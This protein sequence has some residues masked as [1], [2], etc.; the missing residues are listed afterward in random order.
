M[1]DTR[2]SRQPWIRRWRGDACALA[3]LLALIAVTMWARLWREPGLGDWDVSTQYLPWYAFLG[4]H[5]RHLDVPGWNPRIF[6]GSPSAA[7]PQS[8]WMYLPTMALFAVFSPVTAFRLL[9]ASLLA[10][11]GTATYLFARLLGIGVV[12]GLAAGVVFAFGPNLGASTCCSIHLQLSTWLPVAFI[13]IELASRAGSWSHRCLAWTLSAVAVSQMLAAWVGQGAYY[14]LLAIGSFL[15]YRCL[16]TAPIRLSAMR[17]RIGHFAAGSLVTFGVALGLAAAGLLPRLDFAPRTYVGSPAYQGADFAADRGQDWWTVIG[18]LVSYR[19]GWRPYVIGFAVLLCAALA[20]L[21]PRRRPHTW[22]FVV[23]SLVV[24]MLPLRPTPIHSLFYLLPRFR[25]LHLHDPGRVLAILP[26][27]IAMLVATGIDALPDLLR[28]RWA[29]AIP[30]LP[31]VLW[32]LTVPA[33][34]TG[35]GKISALRWGVPAAAVLAL[36]VGVAL[37]RQLRHGI[38]GTASPIVRGLQFVLIGLVIFDPTGYSLY[39]ALRY[40]EN[41]HQ[42]RIA[43][44]ESVSAVDPRGAGEFL[45]AQ[46]RTGAPFRYFGYVNPPMNPDWQLHEHFARSAILPLLAVNR[47]MRLG[48]QDVQGYDPAHLE[49]YRRYLE[50]LNDFQRDYH[51]EAVFPAGLTSPLLDLLNVRFVVVPNRDPAT[52]PSALAGLAPP[53]REVFRNSTV[54]VLENDAALPRAWIVHSSQQTS[55][56]EATKALNAGTI[57]PRKTVLLDAPPPSLLPP[58][59]GAAET[60]AVTGYAD[61]EIR[62]SVLAGSDGMVVMSEVYDPGW[63]VYVDGK[64]SRVYVADGLLRAVAIPKGRHDVRFAYDPASLRIGLRISLGAVLLVIAI[65]GWA[66]ADRSRRRPATE[67][68]EPETA[69]AGGSPA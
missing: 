20:L 69:P 60:V 14:G 4:E 45:Q 51:E 33:L 38:G 53:Y 17:A 48:L 44:A 6:S 24:A 29:P 61:D 32:L 18:I 47:A 49:S 27:G 28:R 16:L 23:F 39:S 21:A 1:A 40:P 2:P 63:R 57:D 52:L 3:V 5:L 50:V 65:A 66:L 43:L 54:H 7:N 22:F 46:A 67:G 55:A 58:D 62:L 35:A 37:T 25:G 9:I 19:P 56:D 36:A 10:L 30:M 59:P 34:G 42:K 12:G 26:I 13:G 15:A 64:E 68:T 8:G 31:A 41:D 11:G